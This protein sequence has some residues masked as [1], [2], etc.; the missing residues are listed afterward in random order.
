[1]AIFVIYLYFFCIFGAQP[2]MGDF[3]IFSY[4]FRTWGVFVFRSTPWRWQ[5]K[6][7]LVGIYHCWSPSQAKNRREKHLGFQ[8]VNEIGEECRQFWAW[9]MG[10]IFF[11]GGGWNPGETRPWRIRGEI[12]GQFS[13]KKLPDQTKHFTP[14]PLCRIPGTT[15]WSASV[16]V[17]VTI[18][19]SEK[20][21]V[22]NCNLPKF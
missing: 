17:S 3:V 10:M 18:Y 15:F 14:S 2:G 21:K 5:F 20:S 8:N 4:F 12:G 6:N 7:I 11:W 22:C 9:I 13:E 1:M 19:N 16:T